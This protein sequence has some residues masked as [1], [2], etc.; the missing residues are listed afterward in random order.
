MSKFA[1][2][3]DLLDFENSEIKKREY[4][5]NTRPFMDQ[6][7]AVVKLNLP[8]LNPQCE[9]CMSC[10]VITTQGKIDELGVGGYASN[11]QDTEITDEHGK[12]IKIGLKQITHN[13]V[14]GV[15]L[16]EPRTIIMGC[17]QV[18]CCRNK[19]NTGAFF[20]SGKDV[21][22]GGSEFKEKVKPKTK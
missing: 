3:L 7:V 9:S 5:G 13:P 19:K 18:F 1:P 11:Q 21:P 6:F 2:L 8:K 4:T 16:R 15:K 10:D 12:K 20:L 14:A 17:G 22:C